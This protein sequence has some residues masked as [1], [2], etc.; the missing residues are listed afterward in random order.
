VERIRG[1]LRAGIG[2]TFVR[3]AARLFAPRLHLRWETLDWFRDPAFDRYLRRYGERHG[4]NAGRRWMVYQLLRLTGKVAGDTAECGVFAGAG[5]HVICAFHRAHA[6]GK[7]H[8]LFDSFA[9]LSEPTAIDGDYWRKHDM[10]CP[11]DVV[12]ANLSAFPDA[13]YHPGWIP[14]SL[15]EVVDRRFSFVHIDVDVYEPTRDSIE[16]FYPRMNDGGVIV[17]DDYGFTTCPG[18]T[19]AIDTFLADKPEKMIALSDGGGF[20]IKGMITTGGYEIVA[21]TR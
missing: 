15:S 7:R 18:A 5:S 19:R 10:A 20:L 13:V 17:C 4:L 14:A 16:F 6:T 21:G 12:R 1:V 8:H 11:I 3:I 9:G 2:F